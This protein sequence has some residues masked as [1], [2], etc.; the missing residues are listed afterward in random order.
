M[1]CG[2]YLW[3][4]F[5]SDVLFNIIVWAVGPN[6]FTGEDSVEFQVHGGSAVVAALLSSLNKLPGFRHAEP[7]DF[8]KRLCQL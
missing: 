8:T 5:I 6:S 3:G 7:G 1:A 4:A 2:G